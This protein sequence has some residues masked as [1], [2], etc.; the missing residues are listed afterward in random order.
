MGIVVVGEAG[1]GQEAPGEGH[2]EQEAGDCRDR[3]TKSDGVDITARHNA[4][5]VPSG[6]YDA[7]KS[8]DPGSFEIL[9]A[10]RSAPRRQPAESSPDKHQ[11]PD[12][13]E[14][15]RR[16]DE[17]PRQRPL[18]QRD[19]AVERCYH[20]DGE[21]DGNGQPGCSSQKSLDAVD[22]RRPQCH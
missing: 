22:G 6:W 19:P 21:H 10:L 4:F 14:D 15:Q 1:E 13:E 9:I 18:A 7:K 11:R 12:G 16:H 20:P 17:N 3:R 2:G 5:F 8:G